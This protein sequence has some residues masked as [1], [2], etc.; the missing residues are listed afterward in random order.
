MREIK[1]RVWNEDK[2]KMIYP[3]YDNVGDVHQGIQLMPDSSGHI[4]DFNIDEPVKDIIVSFDKNT[5]NLMQFTGLKDKDGK[6][7][8]EGDIVRFPKYAYPDNDMSIGA[9]VYVIKDF[10]WGMKE[11]LKDV[12]HIDEPI[13]ELRDKCFYEICEVIGNIYE[14][15]ELIK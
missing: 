3:N 5:G 15:P 4:K 7:I 9:G 2:K 1:F 13:F 8:Y 12:W 10:I 14:N 6:E 11:L